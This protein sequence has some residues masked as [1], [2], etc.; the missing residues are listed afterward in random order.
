DLVEMGVHRF[1]FHCKNP[2]ALPDLF[3][4]ESQSPKSYNSP[5]PAA[6]SHPARDSSPTS[7]ASQW[8]DAVPLPD[9]GLVLRVMA[10]LGEGRRVRLSGSG[11][12]IGRE[13]DNTLPLID[14]K[15]SRYHAQIIAV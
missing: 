15:V 12:T 10:G 3:M 14:A 1:R 4:P 9:G 11:C 8:P 6:F 2:D 13:L 7:A 5:A